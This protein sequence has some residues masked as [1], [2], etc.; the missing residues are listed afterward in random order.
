MLLSQQLSPR[1][2][3]AACR[4][5]ATVWSPRLERRWGLTLTS[6][7]QAQPRWLWPTSCSMRRFAEALVVLLGVAVG[8]QHRRHLT[9]KAGR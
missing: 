7:G 2:V 9:A 4:P 1:V 6:E 8:T 5:F 3:T